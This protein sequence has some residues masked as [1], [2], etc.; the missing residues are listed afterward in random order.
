MIEVSA[1]IVN[2]RGLH[3][4]P[5]AKFAQTAKDY[6]AEITVGK[7]RRW[8]DGKSIASLL[9]LAATCN[10][11]LLIRTDGT[12][13]KQA[14][15]A[16]L[17]LIA[18]G[19]RDDPMGNLPEE[20][21]PTPASVS[22][23]QT[24]VGNLPAH[25]VPGIGITDS[26]VTGSVQ[27]YTAGE[28]Q[29]PHYRLE[30][31]QVAAEIRRYEKALAMVQSDFDQLRETMS[32]SPAATEILPFIDLYKTLLSDPDFSGKPQALIKRRLINAEWAIKERVDA[33]SD[34][35][36]RIP[37]KYLRERGRDIFYVMDRLLA[38]MESG[39]KRWRI[40]QVAA[41]NRIILLAA[42]L[43]PADVIRVQRLGYVGFVTESGSETSHTAILARSLKIPALVGARGVLAR[44]QHGMRIL[45]DAKGE[46]VVLNP[47]AALLRQHKNQPVKKEAAAARRRRVLPTG[48]TTRDGESVFLHTNIEVPTEA[49]MAEGALAD[50]VGLFRTEFLFMQRQAPPGED[51]QFEIYRSVLARL[52]PLPV[53]IRTLDFGGD[54]I[55][56]LQPSTAKTHTNHSAL[57]LRGIRYCL[58]N[59][60][61]F[62]I[63][64]RALLRA[65][66]EHDNLRILIPML[67]H[68]SELEQVMALVASA[69]EQLRISSNI[70][71]SRPPL[72][73]MLEVPASVFIMRVMA[74]YLDFFS[75]GTN[76]LVQYTLAI[77]RN[78]ELLMPLYKPWHPAVLALLSTI[79][80]N[81]KRA[82]KPV[83]LCGEMAG[84]VHMTRL[85][86]GL[87]LRHLSMN[88]DN[89]EAVRECV[90]SSHCADIRP[91]VSRVLRTEDLQKL[92]V[93]IEEMNALSA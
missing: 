33:V 8:V 69:Q 66:A 51:E 64:L 48:V 12:D 44:A 82:K 93:M 74:K 22:K 23:R 77:D 36:R 34:S 35:F 55:P 40:K 20:T 68:P 11:K 15:D 17:R 92:E 60:D 78:E 52:S 25:K 88:A 70:Q 67:S 71:V 65:F 62:L 81:A 41:G 43:D 75:I 9:T 63:Q 28:T 24:S 38:A 73:G 42:D 18:A 2:A 61:I 53:V 27:I 31:R 58:A 1:T 54:K 72:G 59:P 90:R 13:E 91:I 26:I 57:G 56:L 10:T 19:F 83:V 30:K 86:L 87:G 29:V 80:N 85:L 3:A 46:F 84:N 76:D 7:G 6:L 39:R 32:D 79:V 50:G 37:D 16:L 47:N 5:A 89:M 4:R 45:L 21:E 49:V 14:A